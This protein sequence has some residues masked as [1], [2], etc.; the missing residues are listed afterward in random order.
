MAQYF[1]WHAPRNNPD[2][3]SIKAFKQYYESHRKRFR[4]I[5]STNNLWYIK[6]KNLKNGLIDKGTLPLTFSAMHRLSEM[7]RYDP[8]TLNKHLE[9][10]YGW[11]LSEFITKSIHQFVDMISSEITGDDFRVPG[12]R[13]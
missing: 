12:F 9:K 7:P 3:A 10:P 1:H 8:N 11:L 4:Y 5:Y 2:K 13:S 6:R